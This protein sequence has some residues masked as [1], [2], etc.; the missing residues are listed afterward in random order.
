M[1]K[2]R[3]RIFWS[4]ELSA[5]GIL[6]AVLVVFNVV[7]YAQLQRQEWKMLQQAAAAAELSASRSSF[8]YAGLP[9]K[10][11]GKGGTGKS[12]KGSS[13]AAAAL[14]SGKIGLIRA[15][16]DGS[17]LADSG[18]VDEMKTSEEKRLV[19]IILK[20]GES[21]GTAGEVRYALRERDGVYTAAYVEADYLDEEVAET[22]GISGVAL[23]GAAVVFGL[24]AWVL[25]RRISRPAEEAMQAQKQFIADASHELKTPIAVID[26]NIAV[27]EKE[28]GPNKW[29]GY[30]KEEGK[31]L[32]ALVQDLLQLSRIDYETEHRKM[33]RTGEAFNLSDLAL[34][35][36]LPFESVAFE[37]KIKYE[38]QVPDG[39]SAWGC[40]EDIR[41]ILGILLDNA[42]RNTEPQGRVV[43]DIRKQQ[44]NIGRRTR[45]FARLAVENTGETIPPEDLQHLFDRFYRTDKARTYQENNF[46]LGLAIAKSLTERNGG[47]IDVSS[48]DEKNRFCVWLPTDRESGNIS[49]KGGRSAKIR[50]RNNG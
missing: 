24:L 25:A 33:N 27:L 29:M 22:A 47:V 31:R 17:L 50:T 35:T 10:H 20:K 46:G 39:I 37:K 41:H 16:S 34:E 3:R 9:E 48:E 11:G 4:I 6:A 40:K 30:I 14:A 7:N 13:A 49:R 8:F 43:L 21:Q 32:D 36:A 28:I 15:D 42:I 26:A 19:R 38:M 23:L 44:R 2:L 5:V 18:F 12:G 45:R 1:N